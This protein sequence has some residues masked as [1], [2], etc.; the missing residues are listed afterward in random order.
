MRALTFTSAMQGRP[1]AAAHLM[2]RGKAT[3]D[4]TGALVDLMRDILLHVRLDNQTRFKQLAAEALARAESNLV[5]SGH[6]ICAQRLAAQDNMNGWLGEQT[7]GV[8]RIEHLRRLVRQVDEDWPAVH[9][10]LEACEGG[11]R[12]RRGGTE[13]PRQ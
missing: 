8:A 7:G 5:A 10:Q 6:S 2:L 9:R 3:T 4:K 11:W 13:T 1:D 12:A